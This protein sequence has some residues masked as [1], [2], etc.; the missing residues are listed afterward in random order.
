[1]LIGFTATPMRTDKKGLGEVFDVVA[2]QITTKDMIKQ[3]FLV[4]P[5]GFKIATDLDLTNVKTA[6]NDFQQSSLASIMDTPEMNRLVVDAYVKKANNRK[7]IC[8]WRHHRS[9]S[10][11]GKIIPATRHKSSC[12]VWGDARS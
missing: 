3:G 5:V 6:D 10:P 12:C 1:M 8:F 7:C 11:Y 4:Q 9:C 2:Y